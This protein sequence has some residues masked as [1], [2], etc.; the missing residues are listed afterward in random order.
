MWITVRKQN[1]SKGIQPGDVLVSVDGLAVANL[2]VKNPRAGTTAHPFIALVNPS[3]SDDD[4]SLGWETVEDQ[5]VVDRRKGEKACKVCG[6]PIEEVGTIGMSGLL[7][8]H[9]WSNEE[10]DHEARPPE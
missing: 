1:F 9:V 4:W 7:Y 3:G 2:T 5:I 10:A 6:E 8:D